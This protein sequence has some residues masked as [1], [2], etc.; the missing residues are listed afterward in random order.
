MSTGEEPIYIFC[1]RMYPR[2]LGLGNTNAVFWLRSLLFFM[3]YS[4]SCQYL[5]NGSALS[6]GSVTSFRSVAHEIMD[7]WTHI[8]FLMKHR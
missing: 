3:K 1:R 8:I 4:A 5:V 7:G 2:V 6:E